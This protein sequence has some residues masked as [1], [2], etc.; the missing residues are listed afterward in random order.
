LVQDLL[1]EGRSTLFYLGE[2]QGEKVGWGV[3]CMSTKVK[4]F[5]LGRP[6]SGKTT[7]VRRL[8]E[9]ARE[10]DW[11]F[12]RIKDYNILY[13]MFQTESNLQYKKFRPTAHGGF[14][15][16]DMSVFDTALEKL[17]KIVKDE[18]KKKAPGEELIIIEFARDDYRKAFKI[19]DPQF[20]RSSYFIFVDADIE[21]CI[22]RIHDRIASCPATEDNHYV[23]EHIIKSYYDRDNWEYMGSHLKKFYGIEEQRIEAVYNM[24]SLQEYID[25]VNRFAD[26]IFTVR[27]HPRIIIDELR[28]FFRAWLRR[29]SKRRNVLVDDRFEDSQ[30]PL[31]IG[32]LGN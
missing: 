10:R 3:F 9:L 2:F 1:I 19:F 30:T 27:T 13:S 14:D 11:I 28:E 17:E 31:A 23:S 29:L 8:I 4:V 20:L 12:T 15:V 26:T 6:G 32:D 21:T 22:R 5:V 7:A 25:R 16:I 18:E 24:G